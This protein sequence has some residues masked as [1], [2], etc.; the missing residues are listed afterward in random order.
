MYNYREEIKSVQRESELE[1]LVDLFESKFVDNITI[2]FTNIYQTAKVVKRKNDV[3]LD[4][5]WIRDGKRLLK[6]TQMSKSYKDGQKKIANIESYCDEI[7]KGFIK[8]P[9]PVIETDSM[10]WNVGESSQYQGFGPPVP[11]GFKINR[12]AIKK[13]TIDTVQDA[14]YEYI[15]DRIKY[16]PIKYKILN[17]GVRSLSI[18]FK[19]IKGDKLFTIEFNELEFGPL[20]FNAKNLDVYV[21][22][23]DSEVE[24]VLEYI[25]QVDKVNDES[26]WKNYAQNY[27][28]SI[29]ELKGV[30][31][32]KLYQYI[33]KYNI[34][35]IH[36]IDNSMY[37][38]YKK[39]KRR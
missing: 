31:V 27:V 2:P 19:S 18:L 8:Y 4:I 23:L 32:V 25:D 28:K 30:N 11:R 10:F 6:V 35:G 21:Q 9:R 39:Y 20:G 33:M 22:K 12:Y 17:Y 13:Q 24:K 36:W 29:K 14:A 26:I 7:V 38:F 34:R 37:A 5:E 16:I 15:L 1:E 3:V